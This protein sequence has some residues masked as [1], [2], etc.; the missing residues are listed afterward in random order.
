[1]QIPGCFAAAVQP[2][3]RLAT[4]TPWHIRYLS[5]ISNESYTCTVGCGETRK[6]WLHCAII[7]N[8]GM[9]VAIICKDIFHALDMDGGSL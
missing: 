3:F 9:D 2:G 8:V 7:D 5:Y 4:P 6:C 1:M